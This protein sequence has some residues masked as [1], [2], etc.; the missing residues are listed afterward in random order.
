MKGANNIRYI[1]SLRKFEVAI[2]FALSACLKR[3]NM[4]TMAYAIINFA[5]QSRLH[6]RAYRE[7]TFSNAV[8]LLWVVHSLV[9]N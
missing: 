1:A 7:G 9:V 8:I 5:C 4:S 2:A 3:F 6:F